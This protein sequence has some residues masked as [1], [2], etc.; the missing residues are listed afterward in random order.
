[1][2][3]RAPTFRGLAA[4][5][6][7]LVAAVFLAGCPSR[8]LVRAPDDAYYV[9]PQAMAPENLQQAKDAIERMPDSPEACRARYLLIRHFFAEKRYDLLDRAL[10]SLEKQPAGAPW[11]PPAVYLKLLATRDTEGSL[12]LLQAVDQALARFPD[13]EVFQREARK[14]APPALDL[15]TQSDL[16]TFLAATPGGPL[17]PD[18]LLALGL[19]QEK[20]GDLAEAGRLLRR[21]VVAHP[22]ADAAA[23]AYPVLMALS[24][25]VPTDPRAIGALLPM[26]GPRAGAGYGESVEQGIRLALED[27]EARGEHFNFIVKDTR[28]DPEYALKALESLLE[29]SHVVGLFGPLFSASALVCAAEANTRG[30]VL[31]TPSA[32]DAKLTRT[33]PY[34]FRSTLTM[35]Q[36]AR[37]MARFALQ[38]R[39]LARFG[40]IA[41]DT[42]YGRSISEAFAAEVS[43]LGGTV[44]VESRYP[45]ETTDFSSF[46]VEVGGADV[47]AFREAEEEF[48]RSAQSQLEVFLREFFT[49]V[50][51][52]R[53]LLWEDAP[54]AASSTAVQEGEAGEA[55]PVTG[56]VACLLMTTE[57]FTNELGQRLRAAAL[58]HKSISVLAPESA[59]GFSA[60]LTNADVR[61]FGGFSTSEELAL[62]DLLGRQ[63]DRKDAPL[64]VLISVHALSSTVT[65]EHE[66]L[67]CTLAMYNSSTARQLALH[68]FTARRPLP[69]AGNNYELD[70]IY[71]PAQGRKLMQIA[72]QLVYHGIGLPILGSDTWNDDALRKRPEAIGLE[73]FF[74]VG[75][76]P[77]LDRPRTFQFT[78]RYQQRYAAPPDALAAGAYDAACLMMEAALRS[79]GTREGL[80]HSLAEFGELD[81]VAGPLRM[82]DRRETERDAV[83]LEVSNG[84]IA[85]A[86]SF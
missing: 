64:S 7:V 72:P 24:R 66:E 79:D 44:V 70:A 71:I 62:A 73:A 83:I 43:A 35:E 14:L 5:A 76:W 81:G 77:D 61:S 37:T 12:R 8:H 80:R 40:V 56:R 51:E 1:M 86:R 74:T 63:T 26:S 2:T 16:E 52:Q 42:A 58:P 78:Q 30:I 67:R 6:L 25:H 39:H 28:G 75:F 68:S 31:L 19:M 57:P 85:P 32:L 84:T 41:P 15:S 54:A 38:Q 34:V 60:Y 55:L 33:G 22:G 36:Q 11:L 53:G 23:R 49:A 3:P 4:P 48:H 46:I 18:V 17:E 45:A 27:Y 50:K 20:L 9:T 65:V 59:T 10:A 82:T 13:D 47:G 29:E 21:L 69:P